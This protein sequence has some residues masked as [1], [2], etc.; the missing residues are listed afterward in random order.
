MQNYSYIKGQHLL[1]TINKGS[2]FVTFLP[3]L[4]LLS[5][6][7]SLLR[8]IVGVIELVENKSISNVNVKNLL[9]ELTLTVRVPSQ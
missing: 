8:I 1:T 3:S 2:H 7:V 9:W 5:H 4:V 6:G